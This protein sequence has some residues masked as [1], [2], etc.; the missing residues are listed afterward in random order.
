MREFLGGFLAGI[1]LKNK[2]CWFIKS[3]IANSSRL[4]HSIHKNKKVKIDK[5]VQK[6]SFVCVVKNHELFKEKFPTGKVQPYWKYFPNKNVIKIVLDNEIVNYFNYS[7]DD[8]N[9]SIKDVIMMSTLDYSFFQGLGNL[10][11]YI[12]YFLHENKYTNIYNELSIIHQINT[13]KENSLRNKY[14]DIICASI[15]YDNKVEYISSYFKSFF[16]NTDFV[17][18][19]PHVMMY[20]YDKV[21]SSNFTLQLVNNNSIVEKK[22]NEELN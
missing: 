1:F 17:K 20:N 13:N 11:L 19:T 3:S 2:L 4:Y 7:L 10:Y 16:N 5:V 8:L 22:I 15:S 18:I 12:D 9:L 6:I 21:D 14:S